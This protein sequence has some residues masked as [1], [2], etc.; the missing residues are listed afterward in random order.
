MLV[1]RKQLSPSGV[2]SLGRIV[3]PKVVGNYCSPLTVQFN[4]SSDKYVFC[5]FNDIF[6]FKMQKEAETHLPQLDASEGVLLTMTDYDTAQN[7]TF[8]YRFWSNNKSR[9]Y[10]LENTRDFVKAHNLQERD[11]LTLYRD[12]HGS[13]VVRGE[14]NNSNQTGDAANDTAAE[15]IPTEEDLPHKKQ[16]F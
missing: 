5:D 16:K 12:A 11:I 7:W 8:R 14:K 13:Y 6:I 3:L 1:L 4:A 15:D 2:S 9:M 10:L